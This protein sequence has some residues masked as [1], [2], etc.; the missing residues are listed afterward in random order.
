M[1]LNLLVIRCADLEKAAHFYSK[2]GM[3]F[4]EHRHGRGPIHYS[5]EV[6]GVVFEI[7]LACEKAPPTGG[8]RFGFELSS[9]DLVVEE[10]RSFPGARVISEPK[11]SEWGRRAVVGDPFGHKIELLEKEVRL[12]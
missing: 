2:F 8:L 4:V 11:E 6:E 5:A 10:V 1:R 9:L 12:G 7:Y 3:K